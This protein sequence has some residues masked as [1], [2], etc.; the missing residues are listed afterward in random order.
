MVSAVP[1]QTVV[2]SAGF[3]YGVVGADLH[4]FGDGSPLY[5]LQEFRPTPPPDAGWLR[6][7]PSRML[8]ARSGLV[9]FTGRE[10]EQATLREWLGSAGRLAVR[11]LSGPGG[12]GKTR[13]I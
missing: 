8:D 1:E 3:A 6:E 4:V 11:W 10:A 9:P 12:Q 2:A 5:L 7:L 13:L